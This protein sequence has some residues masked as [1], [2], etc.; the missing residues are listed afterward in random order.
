MKMVDTDKKIVAVIVAHPDDET[1][2]AGG[3]LIDHPSWDVFVACLCRKE[4]PDRSGKFSKAM[5]FL[6]TK[7]KMGDMDDG[8]DQRPLPARLVQQTTLLLLPHKQFDLIITHSPDGEYTRHRRHEEVSNAVIEL[9]HSGKIRT[10]EL[11]TFAYEDGNRMYLPRAITTGTFSY[12]PGQETW[13]KKYRIITEIYGFD[14]ESWEAVTTPKQEAFRQ[15]TKP[16][17]AREQLNLRRKE[18]T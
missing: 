4:D 13:Q 2:W 11:W 18:M 12:V 6:G 15:F 5:N 10:G 17:D 1:L 3:L 7:W 16:E 9:W 14:K 8:P